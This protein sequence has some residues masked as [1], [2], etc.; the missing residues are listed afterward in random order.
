MADAKIHC[1][2][3]CCDADRAKLR[4][5]V[6][7]APDMVALSAHSTLELTGSDH[8]SGTVL[9]FSPEAT[10]DATLISD[11]LWETTAVARVRQGYKGDPPADEH[12]TRRATALQEAVPRSVAE[13]L[14]VAASV[15]NPETNADVRPWRAEMGGPGA[16]AGAFYAPKAEDHRSKD[17]LLVARGTVPRLV[18]QLK[19]DIAREAPTYRDLLMSD[20]W[21][22]RMDHGNYMAERNAQ[23]NLVA[24]AAAC[25][26]SIP[27]MNDVGSALASP[28]HALPE[29]AIP[30]W[31][32]QNYSIAATMY[33]GKPVVAMYNGIARAIT[34]EQHTAYVAASPQHGL[35]AFPISGDMSTAN[36][37]VPTA[38][39]SSHKSIAAIKDVMKAAGWNAA[40]HP[41]GLL[42]PLVLVE[43]RE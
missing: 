3:S 20:A 22:K 40:E 21:R 24:I 17:Y 31:Q 41:V 16:F 2:T 28:D 38:L 18:Q 5:L 26:V 8:N 13:P 19:E 34:T 1:A 7:S 9:Y 36:T 23:R 42:V 32:Q 14:S 39:P 4:I 27:R 10:V 11:R 43:Y 37:L 30:D 35:Y 33:G 29:R 12:F 15:R 25:Q 6:E